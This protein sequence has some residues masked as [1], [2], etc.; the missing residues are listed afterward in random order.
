VEKICRLCRVVKPLDEYYRAPGMGDGHRSECKACGLAARAA[1]YRANPG[2]AKERAT[3]WRL[4]NPDRYLETQ[5]RRRQRPEVKAHDHATG[6][7]RGLLCFRCNNAVG[8]LGDDP[9]VLRRATIYL[10]HH[11]AEIVELTTRTRQRLAALSRG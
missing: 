8:D 1:R 7:R 4:A 5:R 9:D 11:D 6:G 2:P 3:A 10:E